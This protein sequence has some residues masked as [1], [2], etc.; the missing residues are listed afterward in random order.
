MLE[1]ALRPSRLLT[2]WLVVGH[3]LAIGCV[4]IAPMD[5]AAQVPAILAL[6]ASA[7]W[8][9]LAHGLR[10][11]PGSVVGL[12]WD[13]D[14]GV[15]V[16]LRDGRELPARIQADSFVSPYL[17]VVR[18]KANEMLSRAVIVLPDTLDPN[19]FRRLRVWLKWRAGL[20]MAGDDAGAWAGRF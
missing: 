9:T 1:I 2:G 10:R 20:G 3:A 13:A 18:L 12:H 5:V 14:G 17:T 19:T 4:V 6:I 7:A 8:Q 11:F 16:R 15:T